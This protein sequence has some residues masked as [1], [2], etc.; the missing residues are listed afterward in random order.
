MPLAALF[1]I[2][3]T[4]L[5]VVSYAI[6]IHKIRQGHTKPHAFSWFIWAIITYIAGAA[7]LSAGGGLGSLVAFTTGTISLWISYHSFRSRAITITR[8]DWVSLVVALAAIPVWVATKNPLLSVIIIS[9]I[10][11]VAFWITIRKSY[12]LPY[13]ENLTQSV[14]STIKHMLTIAAQQQINPVTVLYPASLAM[15][16]AGFTVMLII[17]RAQVPPP[18][19][20]A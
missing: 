9:V 1:S 13:S 4:A 19:D 15:T 8:Q 14:L 7:Q 11:L 3:A 6:Y 20:Q 16:T 18:P 17:R 10:D 2:L 12:H 5:A